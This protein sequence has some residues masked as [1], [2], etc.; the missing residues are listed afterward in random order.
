MFISKNINKQD[1]NIKNNIKIYL[2]DTYKGYCQICGFTF[3][4]VADGQN[5]FQMFNWNDKR[6]VKKKKN[7]ISTAESLCLCRNCSANIKWGE[8]EP[9]FINQINQI[10]NF[11]NR[12]F[13]EIKGII[14]NII[15]K[16]TADVFKKYLDFN[17]IHALEIKVNG[18][19]KNIYFTN[20]HLI[21]FIAYLQLEQ[22][23]YEQEI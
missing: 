1:E 3:R 14:N 12:T 13:E 11:K 4:K 17:D 2:F 16:S 9:V 8:F 6:V 22:K 23:M 15:D 10:E 20:G 18:S 5:S 21:Q 7:F 19:S